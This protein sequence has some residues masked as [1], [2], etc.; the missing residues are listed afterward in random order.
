MRNEMNAFS[1]TGGVREGSAVTVGGTA[2]AVT[3]GSPAR[4]QAHP[5]ITHKSVPAHVLP[6]G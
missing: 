5:A 4:V 1:I 6:S 3:E 2:G